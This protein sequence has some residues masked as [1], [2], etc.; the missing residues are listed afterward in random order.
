[1]LFGVFFTAA[2]AGD[3]M[4]IRLIIKEKPNV[5][6]L[7]HPDEVGCYIFRKKTL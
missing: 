4:I 3:F 7:D 2:A 1:M 6:I 5:Y